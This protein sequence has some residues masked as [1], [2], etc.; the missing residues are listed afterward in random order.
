MSLVAILFELAE[1]LPVVKELRGHLSG[2]PSRASVSPPKTVQI[3]RRPAAPAKMKRA[4][5]HALGS[6]TALTLETGP[7]QLCREANSR[8]SEIGGLGSS[9]HKEI[10]GG[11]NGDGEG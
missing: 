11:T 10:V 9:D 8:V 2:E 1:L 4:S 7:E 6:G 5:S 3:H